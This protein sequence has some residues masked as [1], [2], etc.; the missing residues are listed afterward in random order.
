MFCVNDVFA[1][2]CCDMILIFSDFVPSA[3][4]R[5]FLGYVYLAIL[6]LSFGINLAVLIRAVKKGFL[7]WRLMRAHKQRVKIERNAARDIAKSR[8]LDEV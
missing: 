1:L 8:V 3:T 7:K 5:Y 2:I 6:Y 4:D